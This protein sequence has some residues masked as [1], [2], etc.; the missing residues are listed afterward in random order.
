MIVEQRERMKGVA[1]VQ[2]QDKSF[3]TARQFEN[4]KWLCWT[5]GQN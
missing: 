4:Y 2:L 5:G 1:V 3:D